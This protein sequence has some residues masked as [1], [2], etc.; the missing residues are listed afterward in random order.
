MIEGKICK[1]CGKEFLPNKYRRNQEVC[2]SLEC[3][4]QRQLENMRYWRDLN[5]D[6]FKIREMHD[7][8][9]KDSCKSRSKSWRERHLEY[10]KLYRQEHREEHK[11]YMRDYM[12]EYRKKKKLNE[13]SNLNNINSQNSNIVPEQL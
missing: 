3:Q 5:P 1:I 4:Y 10:L 6:Y 2:S 8:T 11:V 12:R 7:S 9:W 13:N